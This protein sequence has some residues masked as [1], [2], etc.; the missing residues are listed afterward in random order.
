MRITNSMNRRFRKFLNS[1]L[2]I[3]HLRPQVNP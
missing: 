1:V 2:G 3:Q